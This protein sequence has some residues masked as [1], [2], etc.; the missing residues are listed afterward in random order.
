MKAKYKG[1]DIE[2]KRD[3]CLAGYS[4][5][6]YSILKDGY[7]YDYR[8]EDSNETI[9]D[10]IE[11]LKKDVDYLIDCLNKKICPHC[12]NNLDKKYHCEECDEDFKQLI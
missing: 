5:L 6:Y 8:F 2:V 7:E 3:D 12:E 9:H 4:L 10:A 11:Y 1:Y